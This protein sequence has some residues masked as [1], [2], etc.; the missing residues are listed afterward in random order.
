MRLHLNTQREMS[1]RWRPQSNETE[2]ARV[3]E[4]RALFPPMVPSA[5]QRQSSHATPPSVSCHGGGE[6]GVA[7]KPASHSIEILEYQ[8]AGGGEG[9]L[10]TVYYPSSPSPTFL[11]VDSSYPPPQIPAHPHPSANLPH[12]LI[13]LPLLFSVPIPLSKTFTS[14]SSSTKG[15]QDRRSLHINYTTC[16]WMGIMV[17]SKLAVMYIQTTP[18]GQ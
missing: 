3:H 7:R 9:G 12:S 5:V 14:S 18:L 16:H 17:N 2:L 11:P 4:W 6:N 13:P 15:Q 1:T 8:K 10:G